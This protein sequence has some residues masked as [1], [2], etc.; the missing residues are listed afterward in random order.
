MK[1]DPLTSSNRV[2]NRDDQSKD[3]STIGVKNRASGG[4]SPNNA[5]D[6]LKDLARALGY[7]LLTMTPKDKG[8]LADKLS[9]AA[10]VSPSWTWRY[11]HNVMGR[12]IDASEK[13]AGAILK[14]GALLDG[15]NPYA[16]DARPVQIYAINEVAPGS[17]V[18]AA[19][20]KCANPACPI[21]FV[22]RVPNQR[23][24]CHECSRKAKRANGK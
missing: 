16:V 1:P 23:C 13:F 22:P 15:A 14:V 10:G 7:D 21:E 3:K 12:K 18:L 2:I 11:V 4:F 24:C 20:R 6:A 19:S 8:D 5:A 17:L 9:R